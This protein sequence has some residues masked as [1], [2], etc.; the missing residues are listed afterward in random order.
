MINLNENNRMVI[1]Q[2]PSD[3]RIGINDT[4]AHTCAARL[5]VSLSL[6]Q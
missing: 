4:V 5:P 3:I 6:L 1:V 2:H